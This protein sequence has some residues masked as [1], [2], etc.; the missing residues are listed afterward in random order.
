MGIKRIVAVE[1]DTVFPKRGYALDEGVRVGRLGGLPDGL[2]DEEDGVDGEEMVGKVV[3]PYGHVWLEGDN[4]RSS[5]DSNYFG[6][7]SRGLIQGVAV[8]A[9]RG[10]WFGWRKIV[11]ARGEAERKLASRVVEGTE[12]EVP[13]VFLE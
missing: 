13:A 2:V 12:G 10:W 11:D 1:G 9:S 6:P 8:R 3:V 4:G 5:L 7:V